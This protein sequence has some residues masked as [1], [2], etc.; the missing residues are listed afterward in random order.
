MPLF[1]RLI[2]YLRRMRSDHRRLERLADNQMLLEMDEWR[3]W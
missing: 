2:A 1:R 3:V